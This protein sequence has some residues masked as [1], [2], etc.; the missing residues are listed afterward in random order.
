MRI[1]YRQQWLLWRVERRLSRSD[2]HFAAMLAIFAR[3]YVGEAIISAEQAGPHLARRGLAWLGRATA[4]GA[5]WMARHAR[6]ACAA[7]RSRFSRR[8]PRTASAA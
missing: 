4:A 1:P 7:V 5:R 3:L 6:R 2:P 8:T